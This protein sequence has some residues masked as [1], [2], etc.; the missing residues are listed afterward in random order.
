VLFRSDSSW[1]T[2]S[3]TS[4]AAPQ[5]LQATA[6]VAG[7]AAG[8]YMG[9]ITITAPGAQSSPTSITV[10]LTVGAGSPPPVIDVN[11]S[12]DN[13]S[14]ANSI[15]SPA[16]ST[17]SANELLLAFVSTDFTSGTNTTVTGVSGGG[18]TWA[19]VV[20]T[21]TQRGTAEIWSAFAPATLSNVS[22]TATLSLSVA[23]SMTVMTFSGVDTSGTNGSGAIGSIGSN[24]ASTGAPTASL[25]TTRNN[26]L[27]LGVG[28]DYDKAIGRT[29]GAGQVLIH[30]DL[31]SVGDTYWV[32]M[33][34]NPIPL[35]STT[36]T[37][38]DTAP[39]T[40]RFNLSVCSVVPAP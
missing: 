17:K 9:H 4:G 19:L 23:S 8:T 20:R 39:T 13:S 18:L 32:Q 1:L 30:Q 7:L 6:T 37:I 15:S 38:N 10:T 34:T 28:N 35:A 26:S 11:T 24:N 33:Q 21:N 16:F 27:V 31:A 5:T 36:V 14:A 22:V 29:P 12:K 25:V 2:V 3:P 40:D